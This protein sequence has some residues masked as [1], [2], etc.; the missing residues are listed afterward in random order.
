MTVEFP[1]LPRV[2]DAE[3]EHALKVAGAVLIEGPKAAGKTSTAWRQAA[4][5]VGLD[6]DLDADIADALATDP[7]RLLA[8]PTPVLLDEWQLVDVLWNRVRRAVDARGGRP[9]QFILT[10]SSTPDDNVRRHSGAGR[11]RVLAMRPMS[12]FES[13]H[14][15]ARVSLASLFEGLLVRTIRNPGLDRA[16]V[17]QRIQIAIDDLLDQPD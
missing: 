8:G 12:L 2:A 3:L 1:Y 10:G 4:T 13:G 7:D 9:G 17:A 15:S 14:S 5:V 11:F 16:R 6:D